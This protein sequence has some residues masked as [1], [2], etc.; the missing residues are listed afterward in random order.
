MIVWSDHL[1]RAVPATGT[2]MFVNDGTTQA[3]DIR[4]VS[5]EGH[6]LRGLQPGS[7][8]IKVTVCRPA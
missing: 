5:A 8:R 6:T 7:Y 4:R 2:L 1:Q 3:F